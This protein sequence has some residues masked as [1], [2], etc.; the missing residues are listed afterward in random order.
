MAATIRVEIAADG[1]PTVSV[2][3]V[4]GAS[5][6]QLTKDLEKALGTT[7]ENKRTGDFYE[8]EGVGQTNARKETA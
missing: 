2:S 1:T 5:C 4:A 8:I 7:T 6:E 3:G